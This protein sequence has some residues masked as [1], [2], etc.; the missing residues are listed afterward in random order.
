[1]VQHALPVLLECVQQG[2]ITLQKVV[3]KMCHNPAILFDIEQRGYIREGYYA[4]L[5]LVDTNESQ[6][7]ARENV[8]YKC[9]WSPL[10]GTTLRGAVTHTIIN[11][12]VIYNQ[13]NFA[14]RP[15]VKALTFAR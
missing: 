14:Q 7:V 5:V 9:G 8:L 1:M 13:G 3:E 2:K 15:K 6:T 10:E 4:D 12:S 11:G